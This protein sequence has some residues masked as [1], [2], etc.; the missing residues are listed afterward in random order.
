MPKN[1]LGKVTEWLYV[2]NVVLCMIKIV[3]S[4][5]NMGSDEMLSKNIRI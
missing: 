2:Q 3:Y 5:N 1:I 4:A